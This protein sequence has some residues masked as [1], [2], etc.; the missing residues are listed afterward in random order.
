M[1]KQMR[2]IPEEEY[3]KYLMFRFTEIDSDKTSV[4]RFSVLKD[5]KIPDEVKLNVYGNLVQDTIKVQERQKLLEE[6]RF[7]DSNEPEQLS[8]M[9]KTEA[10]IIHYRQ[11]LLRR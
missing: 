5:S 4:N 2:L 11:L 1:A 7:L 8:K 9:I 10:K 6:E 3:Q